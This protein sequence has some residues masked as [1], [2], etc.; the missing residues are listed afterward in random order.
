MMK[1]NEILPAF[2]PQP[3][4]C[5]VTEANGKVN[6][7]GISWFTFLSLAE[8][9]MLFCTSNRGYTGRAI[10]ESKKATFCTVPLEMEQKAMELSK[11]SGNVVD[12]QAVVGF[13]TVTPAGFACCTL[14]GGI[15]ALDLSL[16]SCVPDGDHTIYVMKITNACKLRDATPLYATNQYR[17]LVEP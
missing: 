5:L 8:Q 7:M 16:V 14:A 12:K 9:K 3:F 17:N 6:A 15:M 1:M 13:E 11:C 2:M 10:M 4:G